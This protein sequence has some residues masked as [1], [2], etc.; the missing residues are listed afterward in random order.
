EAGRGG[1]AGGTEIA[2]ADAGTAI[3]EDHHAG[4]SSGTG[5]GN[6][7][8]EGHTLSPH[9]RV[10]GGYEGRRGAGLGNRLRE[11]RRSA[12][13]KG[14]VATVAGR[15]GVA[16]GGEGGGAEG[17]GGYATAGAD[18]HRAAGIAP[19][20]LE[21]HRTRWGAGSRGHYANRG[22]EGGV[23]TPDRGVGCR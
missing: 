23:L 15:Q 4:G 9:R 22:R 11:G 19:I 8:G 16:A 18:R 7:S 21:L 12:R 1:R 14:T 17:G 10:G 5:T 13:A 3:R 2:L 20:H 6:G